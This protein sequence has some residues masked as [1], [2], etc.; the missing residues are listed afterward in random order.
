MS[1]TFNKFFTSV[2]ENLANKITHSNYKNNTLTSTYFN[3]TFFLNP[4]TKH[5]VKNHIL[6]L[7]QNK[8]TKSTCPAIKFYKLGA[9]IISPLISDIFNR[10]I[11]EGV[12]PKSLKSAEVIPI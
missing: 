9:D 6:G 7:N 5:E 1:N 2:G 12:F 8:Q 11:S 4:I 3:K 10:C